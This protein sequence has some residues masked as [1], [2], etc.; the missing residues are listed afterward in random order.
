MKFSPQE[1][2]VIRRLVQI[3]LVDDPILDRYLFHT[4]TGTWV[5]D[6]TLELDKAAPLSLED[7]STKRL[8]FDV[9]NSLCNYP[10][11]QDDRVCSEVGLRRDEIRDLK[12]RV[13]D[14]GV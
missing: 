9:L 6:V 13:R 11:R 2:E 3:A 8:V 12:N 1:H 10:H 7:S 4:L 14:L 5:E